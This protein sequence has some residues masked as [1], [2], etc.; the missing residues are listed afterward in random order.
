VAVLWAPS[1]D[2][3]W[4]AIGESVSGGDG[5]ERVPLT[6]PHMNRT[7]DLVQRCGPAAAREAAIPGGSLDPLAE[8][9]RQ[10]EREQFS[11]P[12]CWNAR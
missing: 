12:G 2:R 6:V 8:G 11:D 10:R 1:P 4:Q 5:H 9:V 7:G 3:V